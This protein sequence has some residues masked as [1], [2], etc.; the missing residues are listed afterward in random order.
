MQ[1]NC[2]W[3]KSYHTVTDLFGEINCLSVVVEDEELVNPELDEKHK[4]IDK[5]QSWHA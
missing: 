2:N 3:K 5:V 4:D 1:N